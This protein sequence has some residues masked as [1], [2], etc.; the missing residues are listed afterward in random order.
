MTTRS[1]MVEESERPRFFRARRHLRGA[2]GLQHV[3]QERHGVDAGRLFLRRRDDA[4]HHLLAAARAG[5]QA[6]ADFDEAHV[7]LARGDDA[8]AGHGHLGAAAEG[9]AERRG[10]DGLRAVTHLHQRVLHPLH[11]VLDRAPPS[12]RPLARF[13]PTQKS[14]P[15]LPMTRPFQSPLLDFIHRLDEH[16]ADVR[17]ERVHLRVELEA[18]HAVAE[19]DAGWR[20]CS[21]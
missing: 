21:P 1:A 12:M 2:D 9:A 15:S 17:V 20:P 6:D 3:L 5:D 13:A 11:R 18:E 7:G 10:D 14:P 4:A 16:R 8:R 19:V